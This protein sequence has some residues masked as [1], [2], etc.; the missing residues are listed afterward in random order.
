MAIL[1]ILYPLTENHITIE[2]NFEMDIMNI[3]GFAKGR[4]RIGTLLYYIIS[5]ILNKHFF[6][7]VKLIS[8]ETSNKKQKN[9]G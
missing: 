2:P 6:N 8:K 3:N 4:I 5:F 9:G 1:G 7:F